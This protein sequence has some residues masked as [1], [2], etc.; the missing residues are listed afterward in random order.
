MSA[1]ALVCI[2][3]RT[4]PATQRRTPGLPTPAP[5]VVPEDDIDPSTHTPKAQT[6][7]DVVLGLSRTSFE[8]AF[9]LGDIIPPVTLPPK[10][11]FVC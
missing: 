9:P 8:V 6:E 3:G 10:V 5:S 11:P 4:D 1:D 2:Q 7:I